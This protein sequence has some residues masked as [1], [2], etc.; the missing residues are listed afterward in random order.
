VTVPDTNSLD[1]TTGM[2]LEAWVNP[3]QLGTAWRTVLFKG[4]AGE[5]SCT[6]S[7]RTRTRPGRSVRSSSEANRTRRARPALPL[8]AWTHLAV[9]FDGS[10]LRLYV[11]GTVVQSVAVIGTLPVFDRRP[12]HRWETPCGGEWYRG[13]IDDVSDLQQGV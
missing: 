5:S 9:T 1:L 4:A 13:L 12:P 7:M 11:N 6:A 2:T 8:N 3:N 10:N